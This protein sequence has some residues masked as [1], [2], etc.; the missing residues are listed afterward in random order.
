MR[1]YNKLLITRAKG[2]GKIYQETT[3]RRLREQVNKRAN[4]FIVDDHNDIKKCMSS[5]QPPACLEKL[6][7]SVTEQNAM[8]HGV[9]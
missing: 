9:S 7:T 2:A 8:E 6:V 5:E 4:S 1:N 3:E